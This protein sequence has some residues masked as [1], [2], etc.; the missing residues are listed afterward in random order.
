VTEWL[1]SK[2]PIQIQNLVVSAFGWRL[3]RL[4][5][6][7]DFERR[8]SW[9]QEVQTMSREE[10]DL[11]LT[12][13]LRSILQIA[14]EHTVYGKQLSEK[15]GIS[16]D[17]ISH[18]TDIRQLPILTKDQVRSRP[19]SFINRSVRKSEVF[20]DQTSGTTGS[21]L[22]VAVS[23]NAL[24]DARA[25]FEIAKSWAGLERHVRKATFNGRLIV[26]ADQSRPPYWRYNRPGRQMLF[27]VHHISSVTVS[28]Y[29]RKLNEYRPQ[30]LDG[31]P[32]AIY[33]IARMSLAEGLQLPRPIAIIPWAETLYEFQRQAIEE[34]FNAPM[35]DWYGVAENCCFAAQCK[36][37]SYHVFDEFGIVEI[38]DE[39]G[40]PV[41]IGE[42]GTVVATSLS[43]SAMPLLRYEV[44][45]RAEGVAEAQII[46]NTPETICVNIVPEGTFGSQQQSALEAKLRQRL[47]AKI[48]IEF[49]VVEAIPRTKAG[50]Y[51]L[52]N[53]SLNIEQYLSRNTG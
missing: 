13:R 2:L 28:H 33:S 14:I 21:P 24:R 36:Y 49:R 19:E 47:G 9:W 11:L 16:P 32:S 31:Y 3:Q 44:G 43:N 6:G 22:R 20:Y 30:L 12:Q 35:F 53:S 29:V 5:Y 45:D 40:Q 15:Y 51:K 38:C 37:G 17:N 34:A 42:E 4:R 39:D 52:V 46:Q 50:K 26:P 8:L 10:R 25:L 27:S 7:G 18:W 41:K 1:Y 48:E 23:I